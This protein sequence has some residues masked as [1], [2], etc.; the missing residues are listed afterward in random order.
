MKATYPR[1]LSKLLAIASTLCVSVNQNPLETNNRVTC[2]LA[3]FANIYVTRKQLK[4]CPSTSKI[5]VIF[6]KNQKH[7]CYR[8]SSKLCSNLKTKK[9]KFRARFIGKICL[10]KQNNNK[11]F[12]YSM[13][14]FHKKVSKTTA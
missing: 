9:D 5:M 8:K 11:S 2:S 10:T 3:K 14:L 7:S 12:H 4:M 1:S 6:S 13:L